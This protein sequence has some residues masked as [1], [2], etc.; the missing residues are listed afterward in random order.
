MKILKP[1]FDAMLIFKNFDWLKTFSRQSKCFKK[2]AQ[3]KIYV[4]KSLYDR[5]QFGKIVK[6]ATIIGCRA[7][8][9]QGPIQ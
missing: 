2:I 9:K 4:T 8:P 1:K 6:F 3:P 7:K 5:S